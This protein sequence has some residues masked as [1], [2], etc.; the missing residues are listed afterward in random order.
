M[1]VDD[2]DQNIVCGLCGL[3]LPPHPVFEGELRFCCTG[4]HA[5]FNILATKN[6][7]HH[8]QDHPLFKQ[9]VRCGLISNPSLLDQ[10]RANQVNIPKQEMERLCLEINDMWCPSCAEAIRLILLHERGVCHC[11]V[12][13][14]TDLASI[15]Y[16]PRYLSKDRL[17]E[18]IAQLG[19]HPTTLQT[20][21]R[22]PV[23]FD[24]YLKFAIAVFCSLN[25]MMFA[26][27]LYAT[28]F[29]GDDQ[30]YGHLFAW[31]SFALSLPVVTYCAMPIIRKFILSLRVGMFGMETLVLLGVFAAFGL[32]V[33]ELFNG[34]T[35]VYF[36]SM[37]VIVVFVLL[38]KII[39]AKAKFTAKE[40]Y[41]K[42]VRA[43][44]RKG[45]KRFADGSLSFTSIKQIHPGDVIVAFAGEKIVLDGCVIEGEGL[46]DEALMTGEAIPVS[47]KPGNCVLGGSILQGGLL[48]I[49]V[50]AS[51]EESALQRILNMVEQDISRKTIYVRAADKIVR[52]FVPMVLAIAIFSGLYCWLF[53]VP[54]ADKTIS[55]TALLRAVSVLLISCPC[56]IGIAA[57]LADAYLM[58][59]LA[60]LGAIIRNRA[61]LPYLGLET[62]FV[63]DKTGTITE[64][65][66]AV[67]DGLDSLTSEQRSRLKGLASYSTHPAA[68]A[69]ARSIQETP[70]YFSKI[71]EI[72]GRG[73]RGL[74]ENRCF[75]LGSKEFL[76]QNGVEAPHNDTKNSGLYSTVYYSEDQLL[77]QLTL[78]DRIRE[79]AP[80][81]IQSLVPL[82]RVLLSGD[83]K[84][85]VEQV[86]RTCGFDTWHWE[87]TPLQKREYI[88]EFVKNGNI[89]CMLGDGINDAPALTGAH[90]GISVLSATDISIQVSDILLTTDRLQVISEIRRLARKGRRIVKQNLFWAFFYNVV[91]IGLAVQGMLSPIFAAFAMVASSL[92]VLLNAQRLK[93]S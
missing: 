86:G 83:S 73:L 8:F 57:P 1:S 44:P 87:C 19:Y 60:S 13:Y 59:G 80:E 26:Y 38:G 32:S 45:R 22:R 65:R 68:T 67:I 12:D 69:I 43:M 77:T 81:L 35:R 84:S 17:F 58:N 49:K 16:A 40:A 15:E 66:F 78:G 11:V 50:T 41:L 71:E 82:H 70:A 47:K 48:T 42:L 51:V 37:T 31:L 36:D 39:E 74:M 3:D 9:A 6:E 55:A 75:L 29:H 53:G 72:I 61:C 28:Y 24:L 20:P 91:G 90:V 56:A 2:N 23:S 7:L 64:G 85:S 14:T 5:V 92:I 4:C 21:E 30:G 88:N 89:V 18:I 76:L 34:G 93:G 46:C 25:V 62:M 63:F 79:E 52:W 27:P 10:I 54:D 33:F